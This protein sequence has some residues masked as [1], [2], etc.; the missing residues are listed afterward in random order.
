[1]LN[2]LDS[3]FRRKEMRLGNNITRDIFQNL[4]LASTN[5]IESSTNW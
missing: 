4:P 1:L 2:R 5:E 3:L